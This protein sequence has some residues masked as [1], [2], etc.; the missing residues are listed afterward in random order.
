[1]PHPKLLVSHMDAVVI[2]HNV[3]ASCTVVVSCQV[4]T[5][6]HLD[7]IAHSLLTADSIVVVDM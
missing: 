3:H 4:L 7:V 6:V 5:N 1:L 2:Q